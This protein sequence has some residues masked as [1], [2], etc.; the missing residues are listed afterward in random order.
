MDHRKL[1]SDG[2]LKECGLLFI[3]NLRLD[4]GIDKLVTLGKGDILQ[5]IAGCYL[6]IGRSMSQPQQGVG[7]QSRHQPPFATSKVMKT[8]HLIICL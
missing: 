3:L 2:V 4:L 7:K 1:S 6:G 5:G 8:V